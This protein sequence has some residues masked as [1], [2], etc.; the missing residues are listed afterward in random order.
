MR[1]SN[2]RAARREQTTINVTS[3]VDIIF[4]LLIFF[5]L[6][7]SFSQSAGLEV[8]LPEASAAEVRASP[9][10]LTVVLT[11]EGDRLVSGKTVDLE[12]L[13]RLLREHKKDQ[14]RGSVIVQADEEVP[15]GNVVEVIDAARAEGMPRLGIATRAP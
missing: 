9:G 3:L 15:H 12:E 4:I 2:P 8:E 5:L 7:T 11:K 1:F 14:P 13:R 10:D 6:T